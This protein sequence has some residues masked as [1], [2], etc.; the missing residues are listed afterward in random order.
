[1][2][3]EKAFPERI[4]ADATSDDRF[5]PVGFADQRGETLPI[6]RAVR[7]STLI[8]NIFFNSCCVSLDLGCYCYFPHFARC[9]RGILAGAFT[10]AAPIG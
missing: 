5:W 9:R 6:G 3:R 10:S 8:T 2:L 7:K 4:D 1:M